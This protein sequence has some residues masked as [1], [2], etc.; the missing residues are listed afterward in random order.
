M[1]KD[2]IINKC[3][4]TRI[5]AAIGIIALVLGTI[6]PYAKYSILGYKYNITLWGYWEGKIVMLLALANLIFIFRDWV[7][8]YIPAL[9]NTTYGKK[10]KELDNTKYS[11]VPTVLIAIFIIFETFNL[12]ISFKYYNIGFYS[13]WLGTISLVAYAILH[14]K[15]ENA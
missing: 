9:F 14:K 10:I 11:L 6:M 13:V 2:V 1:N 8:K 15:N 3:K 12:D 7:E 4:N 5:L